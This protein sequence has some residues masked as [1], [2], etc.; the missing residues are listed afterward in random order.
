MSHANKRTERPLCAP[1][2]FS[3]VSLQAHLCK[4]VNLERYSNYEQPKITAVVFRFRRLY[5][6]VFIVYLCS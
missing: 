2:H 4:K 5:T 3:E 6:R 1:L